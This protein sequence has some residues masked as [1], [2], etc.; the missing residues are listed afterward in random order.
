M[1]PELSEE[2]LAEKIEAIRRSGADIVVTANP[3]CLL[4]L[5]YGVA[6]AGLN[7]TVMHFAAALNYNLE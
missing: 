1:Q 3:G 5:Q 2:L 7:V 4:Q 6:K